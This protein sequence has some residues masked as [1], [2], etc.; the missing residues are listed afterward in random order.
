MAK[1]QRKNSFLTQKQKG[2]EINFKFCDET[3]TKKPEKERITENGRKS[4]FVC[5]TA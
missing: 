3:K 2:P 1:E 5:M 4:A